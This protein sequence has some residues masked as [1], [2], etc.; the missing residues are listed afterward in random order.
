[1]DEIVKA[2]VPQVSR[3]ESDLIM[4]FSLVAASQEYPRFKELLRR[5]S[6]KLSG[7]AIDILS[8]Y[9]ATNALWWNR[10]EL[11][12]NEDSYIKQS[13]MPMI[14]AVFGSL[15]MVQHWYVSLHIVNNISY[16][17]DLDFLIVF[18]RQCDPLPAPMG[19]EEVLQPDF[20]GEIEDLC[21]VVMEVKKPNA[22]LNNILDDTR[23]LPSMMK[24]ALNMLIHA[25][26][27]NATVLG[28][29]VNG[30]FKDM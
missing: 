3:H 28:F 10:T 14:D 5:S 24:I 4:K 8:T 29:L 27:R 23:K 21:F 12:Q 25:N 16:E 9:T 20:F 22:T 30:M 26:V 11:S 1:V 18:I 7:L 2:D 17:S 13:V 6:M 19:Y 15:N